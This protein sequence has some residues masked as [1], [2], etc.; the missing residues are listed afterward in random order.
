LQ[1]ATHFDNIMAEYRSTCSKTTGP[2]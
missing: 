2:K 1:I